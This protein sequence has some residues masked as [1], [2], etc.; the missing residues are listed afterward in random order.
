MTEFTRSE[1]GPLDPVKGRLQNLP[2]Y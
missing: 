2:F 1:N